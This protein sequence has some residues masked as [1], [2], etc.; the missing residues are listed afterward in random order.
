M[1]A[2]PQVRAQYDTARF[3][4][5][6]PPAPEEAA[7]AKALGREPPV[8]WAVDEGFGEIRVAPR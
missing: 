3:Q 8:R 5:V 6:Q 2:A 1:S 7:A 4:R